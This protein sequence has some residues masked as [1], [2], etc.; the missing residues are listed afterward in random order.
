MRQF[1]WLFVALVF[2]ACPPGPLSG[3]GGGLPQPLVIEGKPVL[4]S[5]AVVNGSYSWSA[6]RPPKAGHEVYQIVAIPGSTDVW[7]LGA[8]IER[9][10]GTA[11]TERIE[12]PSEVVANVRQR[13]ALD[14]AAVITA[15]DIWACGTHLMHFDGTT[16]TNETARVSAQTY[17][18]AGCSVAGP[19][20]G[21][22]HVLA[23]SLW[24]IEGGVVSGV[25]GNNFVDDTTGMPVQTNTN[26]NITAANVDRSCL[27]ALP[28]GEAG[29]IG[30]GVVLRSMNNQL[31]VRRAF[32]LYGQACR[33]GRVGETLYL[34]GSATDLPFIKAELPGDFAVFA[35]L[36]KSSQDT[37]GVL[38]LGAAGTTAVA[39][40]STGVVFAMNGQDLKGFSVN[41][42]LDVTGGN[43][44]VLTDRFYGY[45]LSAAQL[46]AAGLLV[47]VQGGGL[48][49]GVK[50]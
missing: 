46:N 44:T 31:R 8:A 28:T 48:F 11:V 18:A 24:V 37:A 32:G 26:L 49:Q 47:A 4:G 21:K 38:Y 39:A 19:S 17:M 7:L 40:N 27:I 10:N 45:A 13:G 15:N 34:V 20:G 30:V 42:L 33:S 2:C 16:W 25:A 50:R 23:S 6:L 9:W 29:I 41:V 36:P 3:D 5:V 14:S 1:L 22:V 12:L 35:T 43:A